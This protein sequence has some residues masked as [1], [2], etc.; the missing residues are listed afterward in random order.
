MCDFITI[1]NK[2]KVLKSDKK[3]NIL[4]LI[5]KKTVSFILDTN[6]IEIPNSLKKFNPLIEKNQLFI[7]N[8]GAFIKIFPNIEIIKK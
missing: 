5:G 8:G 2:G 6:I 3:E 4:N 1:I 7:Q